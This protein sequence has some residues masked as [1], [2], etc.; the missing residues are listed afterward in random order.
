MMPGVDFRIIREALLDAFSEEDLRILLREWMDVR[1]DH[2]VGSGNLSTRIF[3]LL[4]WSE[5]EGRETELVRAAAVNRPRHAK[6]QEV[7]RKYGMSVPVYVEKSGVAVSGSPTDVTQSG[8]ERTVRDHLSFA[9]FGVW[10]DRM[11]AVEGRVCQITLRG[12]AQGTGFLVGPDAVLT[13]YHVMQPVLSGT[14]PPGDVECVFDFKKL[15]DGSLMRTPVSLHLSDW[16]ID[17]CPYTASEFAGF[18]DQTLPTADELDY[19]LIRLAAPVGDQPWTAH[20]GSGA[21]PRG[22]IPLP[23]AAPVLKSP[24]GVIIAQHPS[25]WPMKLGIDTLAIDRDANPSLWLNSNGTRVRYATNTEGGS[26]GSPV[27]DLEWNLIALHHYGD[28]Q[29]GH[30]AKWNQGIPVDVIRSRLQRLGK[31]ERLGGAVR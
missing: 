7:S 15:P 22:W 29:R 19:A 12:Q 1:L 30:P 2:V 17:S 27:F 25:G 8:L 9:D 13:N 26:S 23:E 20:P 24:M 4:E 10:R 3:E 21:P 28:P 5:R 6:M 18:P 11:T 14:T 31:S 16:N